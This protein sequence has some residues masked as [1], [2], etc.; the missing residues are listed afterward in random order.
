M[1]LP[2]SNNRSIVL[3]MDPALELK[4]ALVRR[5]VTVTALADLAGYS[6]SHLSQVLNGRL[7]ASP[8]ILQATEEHVGHEARRLLA[9]LQHGANK[10]TVR[11]PPSTVV[12]RTKVGRR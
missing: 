10:T 2:R 7:P 6:R 11:R 9:L 5:R 3:G 12:A 8:R 4:A 1:F